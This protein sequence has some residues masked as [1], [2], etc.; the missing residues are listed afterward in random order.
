MMP[1]PR[2][3]DSRESTPPTA[4]RTSRMNTKEKL[5]RTVSAPA[6]S[7][8]APLGDLKKGGGGGGGGGGGK[9]QGSFSRDQLISKENNL[10]ISE[11]RSRT[12]SRE[13]HHSA[14]NM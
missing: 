5:A 11:R 8:P 7:P 4:P 14:N 6:G 9:K 13:T 10:T 1:M 3:S 2:R 12:R